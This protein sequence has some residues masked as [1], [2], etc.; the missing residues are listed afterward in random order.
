MLSFIKSPAYYSTESQTKTTSLALLLCFESISIALLII[1]IKLRKPLSHYSATNSVRSFSIT[2][3]IHPPTNHH[4]L[5][6]L[7][8]NKT[9]FPFHSFQPENRF[10]SASLKTRLASHNPHYRHQKQIPG[11]IEQQLHISVARFIYVLRIVLVLLLLPPPHPRPIVSSLS[12]VLL[13]CSV[14]IRTLLSR[15]VSTIL[16]ENCPHPSKPFPALCM[17]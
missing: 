10:A 11:N 14:I 1:I 9:A 15:A 5:T 16:L 2:I 13:L 17:L 8:R 4:H 3:Q 7:K 6:P 12:T